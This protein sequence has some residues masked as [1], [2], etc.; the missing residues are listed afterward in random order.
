VN[1]TRTVL[2]AL[3]STVLA[4]SLTACGGSSTGSVTSTPSAAGA[5][6]T[7]TSAPAPSVPGMSP[8]AVT[9][10][11]AMAGMAMRFNDQDVTFAADMI[12]H[13]RQA[14]QMVK[15]APDRTTTKAVLALAQQIQSAQGPEITMMSGWLTSWGKPIPEDMSGMD[16]GGSMPGMMSEAALQ[17]LTAARGAAFDRL[18]LTMMVS[19]HQGAITMARTQFARGT[20]PESVALA[21]KVISDQ[22][23][24]IRTMQAMLH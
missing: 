8:P 19:H 24:Q 22:A 7:A 17:Q 11:S 12:D 21:K 15:L 23:A 4:A 20:N 2:T 9:S 18:F 3:A 6:A 13:H 1:P 10:K 16:M 14:V 5:A